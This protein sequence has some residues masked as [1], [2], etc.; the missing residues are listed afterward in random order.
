MTKIVDHIRHR[1][2]AG[3]KLE[4]RNIL[5]ASQLSPE[6]S[7]RSFSSDTTR[8][9][10]IVSSIRREANKAF[11]FPYLYRSYS[12]PVGFNQ[13]GLRGTDAGPAQDIY[14]VADAIFAASKL[15]RSACL[16]SGL[17][18]PS[19]EVYEEVRRLHNTFNDPIDLFLSLGCG[20]PKS[21][22]SQA[23]KG[24]IPP[25]KLESK[26]ARGVRRSPPDYAQSK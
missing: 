3:Y 16:N 18:N 20:N 1:P 6:E 24:A 19:F 4:I 21:K 8:C 10:T 22:S 11:F 25:S 14:T 5:K 15:L 12:I 2:S 9:K 23:R 13:P 7:G 26:P 17:N